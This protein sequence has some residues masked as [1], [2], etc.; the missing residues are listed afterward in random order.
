MTDIEQMGEVVE[1]IIYNPNPTGEERE[2]AHRCLVRIL[3][4]AEPLGRMTGKK[5]KKKD[6]TGS[7]GP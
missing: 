5:V 2:E 1:K 7:A 3:E 6:V 4:I